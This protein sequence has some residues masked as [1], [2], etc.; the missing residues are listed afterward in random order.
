MVTL[1]PDPEQ[2]ELIAVV[3]RGGRK[4]VTPEIK[5][6]LRAVPLRHTNRHPFSDVAV[7]L[8]WKYALRHAA[9]DEAAWLHIV[10]ERDQRAELRTLATRAHRTQTMDTSFRAEPAWNGWATSVTTVFRAGSRRRPRSW[11]GREGRV[12]RH[13]PGPAPQA[14]AAPRPGA[15]LLNPGDAS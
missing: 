10:D 7:A 13:R 2:P 11:L 5:R 3:R 6:M 14:A 4:P 1:L 15:L 8:P 9:L 12:R